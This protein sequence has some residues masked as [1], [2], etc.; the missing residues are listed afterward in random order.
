MEQWD[1]VHD[2]IND[3]QNT[4]IGLQQ[5]GDELG[6]VGLNKIEAAKKIITDGINYVKKNASQDTAK[7]IGGA[8]EDGVEKIL[9]AHGINMD[10]YA[11]LKRTYGG[12]SNALKAINNELSSQEG[13]QLLSLPAMV[14]GAGGEEGGLGKMGL[15]AGAV[16]FAKKRGAGISA[17]LLNRA[18]KIPPRFLNAASL[19]PCF[20]FRSKPMI[21]LFHQYGKK[22]NPNANK[23]PAAFI[24]FF[25]PISDNISK[26]KTKICH[27]IN[28]RIIPPAIVTHRIIIPLPRRNSSPSCGRDWPSWWY[29]NKLCRKCRFD[30]NATKYP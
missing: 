13:N 1:S 9:D 30:S 29:L 24:R 11:A 7:R 28:A 15:M 26:M 21:Y 10:Q 8:I 19:G 4:I 2:A 23:N 12:S 3:A 6:Q 27:P 18:S 25:K 17:N 5:K 14:I 20:C 16:D 22:S